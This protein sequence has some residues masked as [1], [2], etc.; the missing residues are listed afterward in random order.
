MTLQ[1]FG[2]MPQSLVQASMTRLMRDVLPRLRER[3]A[4]DKAF[5]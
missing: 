4:H 3:V 2:L 1:N 5:A